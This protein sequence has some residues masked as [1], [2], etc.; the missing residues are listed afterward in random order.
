[1]RAPILDQ[2]SIAMADG[3]VEEVDRYHWDDRPIWTVDIVHGKERVDI[4]NI[5]LDE[6]DLRF[7]PAL[8]RKRVFTTACDCEIMIGAT[9]PVIGECRDRVLSGG[10]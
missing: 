4:G 5:G 9:A 8:A 7:F 1:M 3:N 10:Q 2:P 6:A